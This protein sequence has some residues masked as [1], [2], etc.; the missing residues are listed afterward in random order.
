MNPISIKQLLRL[1]LDKLFHI[2]RNDEYGLMAETAYLSPDTILF[3]KKNL[4]MEEHTSIP[5]GAMILNPRSK[6]IMKKRSFASYNLCVCPGNHA[7]VKGMWKNEVSDAVKDKMFPD[8]RFDKDIVV[9]E[10]VWMGIN[11]TLLSGA[12]IGRGCIIGAGC[13]V[14]GTTPPYSVIV[15]NP[16]RII[17]FVFKPEEIIEHEKQLYPEEE[18][19]P[20][21]VLQRNYDD[22]QK[23]IGKDV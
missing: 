13:V 17:K 20:L 16:W 12:H 11:V 3:S 14:S 23:S 1:K 5:G 22:W 7:V 21:S 18:R 8:K 10:D 15:G 6:F 9:E 19:L 4:C 2:K